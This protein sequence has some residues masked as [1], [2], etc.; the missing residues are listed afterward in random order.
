MRESVVYEAKRQD[1][2]L[3]DLIRRNSLLGE[4]EREVCDSLNLTKP[5]QHD[6]SP[7][8]FTDYENAENVTTGILRFAKEY[9]VGPGRKLA[10][11]VNTVESFYKDKKFKIICKSEEK[12]EKPVEGLIIPEG[13][14]KSRFIVFGRKDEKYAIQ[15]SQGDE[16]KIFISKSS[17]PTLGKLAKL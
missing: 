6:L 13:Y 4:L 11:I 1:P 7:L 12:T 17:L 15:V 9:G 8:E 5:W 2:I 14:Y 3:I 10:N 16:Y